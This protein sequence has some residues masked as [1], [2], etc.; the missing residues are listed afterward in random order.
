VTPL[1]VFNE[2]ERK[3]ALKREQQLHDRHRA[4]IDTT[5][6]FLVLVTA[7][8]K[9]TLLSRAA[10]LPLIPQEVGAMPIPTLNFISAAGV[11]HTGMA[12][13]TGNHIAKEPFTIVD[14]GYSIFVGMPFRKTTSFNIA[15]AVCG[16]WWDAELYDG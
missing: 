6:Q 4:S 5:E 14:I 16:Q 8:F 12:T 11:R 3:C 13:Y 1:H 15:N 10:Q 7:V 2:L 9:G